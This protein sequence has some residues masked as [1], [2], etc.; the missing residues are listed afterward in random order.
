M[1]Q[2]SSETHKSAR[3]ST[4]DTT[5]GDLSISFSGKGWLPSDT[6]VMLEVEP[7]ILDFGPVGKKRKVEIETEIKNLTSEVMELTLLDSP[8]EFFQE[9]KL[10]KDEIKPNKTAKLKIRLKREM[11]DQRFQKSITLE[12]KGKNTTYRIT[13]PIQKGFESAVAEKKPSESEQ[14]K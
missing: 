4:N 12:I 8:P 14:K 10:S 6:S 3:V 1:G 5:T 11:E 13:L 7:R 9:V 2:H